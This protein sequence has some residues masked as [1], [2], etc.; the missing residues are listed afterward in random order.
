MGTR[1]HATLLEPGSPSW[2]EELREIEGPPERL[3]ARGRIELLRARPRVAIVGSRGATPYG[4]EQARRF[5]AELAAAGLA[6]VSGLARGIDEE[7]HR[8]AL[9]VGGATIAVLGSGV[10]RPWPSGALTERLLVDGLLLSEHEPGRAP[11]P[12]HFP[13]RN[14]LISGLCRAVLV[15]EAAHASGSLITA[16]WAADQGRLVFAL[17]GR[18]D[19]ATARGAHRL[20]RE[21]ASLVEDPAEILC[22]LGL[23]PRARETSGA[24]G[25]RATAGSQ[26]LAAE[27]LDALVGSRLTVDELAERLGREP[28][29]LLVELVGLELA[30]LVER[31]PGG[32][33]RVVER[34]H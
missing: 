12:H 34:R 20:I 13:L 32:L 22:E 5:A 25:A 24:V 16:R 9:D 31:G 8:A 29:S 28:S 23:G 2:P 3:W 18:V 6:V 4:R 21:G 15:V 11:R 26:G 19:Q 1:E 30:G 33:L 17:P 7:A 27:V 14:R 10:D